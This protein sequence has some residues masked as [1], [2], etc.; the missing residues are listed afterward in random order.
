MD[1]PSCEWHNSGQVQSQSRSLP[2]VPCTYRPSLIHG[3]CSYPQRRPR[4]FLFWEL[5]LHREI[6]P[7]PLD[8]VKVY[9]EPEGF[10]IWFTWI[11][12]LP[13]R[14]SLL[15]SS[16][17]MPLKIRLHVSHGW[18]FWIEGPT[19]RVCTFDILIETHWWEYASLSFTKEPLDAGER[20]ERKSWLKTQH[21]KKWRS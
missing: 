8:L 17:K 11:R 13:R 14:C 3:I 6:N 21:S 15:A 2:H 10:P 1:S 9:T 12:L 5:T 4:P 18:L 20:V 16:C 7:L 19:W